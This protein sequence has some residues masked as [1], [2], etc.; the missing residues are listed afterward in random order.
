MR[1]EDGT[2]G[3]KLGRST[4]DAQSRLWSTAEKNPIASPSSVRL[5]AWTRKSDRGGRAM[6]ASVIDG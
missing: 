2:D 4:R 1:A 5:A 6:L 3:T